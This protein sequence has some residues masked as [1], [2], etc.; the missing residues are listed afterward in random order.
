MDSSRPASGRDGDT[1][2]DT[3]L[4]ARRVQEASLKYRM[5]LQMKVATMRAAV[6][7]GETADPRVLAVAEALERLAGNEN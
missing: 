3:A 2:A 4:V 1:V 5:R 7:E 6:T